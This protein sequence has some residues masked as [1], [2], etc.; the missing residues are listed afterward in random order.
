M[1]TITIINT[2][3]DGNLGDGWRDN[4][5]AAEALALFQE[6]MWL[7]DIREA[8]IKNP[9][10][11]EIDV[12]YNTTGVRPPVSVLCESDSLA[13]AV[14]ECLTDEQRIWDIFCCSDEAEAL[15]EDWGL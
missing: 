4:S 1:E 5:E 8:G 7:A 12:N 15:G 2:I 11:F 6:K 3:N 13:E 9:V 10:N 14:E